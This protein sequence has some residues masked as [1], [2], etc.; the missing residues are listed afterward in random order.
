[1]KNLEHIGYP[2]YCVT[3]DGK[4]FSIL[5]NRFLTLH[6]K[7]DGYVTVGLKR[8]TFYVHRLVILA[9]SPVDDYE[10][11]QVN[12]KDGD[13]SNNR[14]SNLEWSTPQ[15]NSLHAVRTGL[16]PKRN[17]TDEQV[18]SICKMLEDGVKTSEIA[19]V[20]NCPTSTVGA[21]KS[22][23]NFKYISQEYNW[24]SRSRSKS[25]TITKVNAI[26]K[27]F[28]EGFSTKEVATLFNC[29]YAVVSDIR[30]RRT[31]KHF[32]SHLDW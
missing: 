31:F 11:L 25:L 4:V 27:K 23:Q 13:K 16:N 22:G 12:H 9:Y 18:H 26:C 19:E 21:I 10:S 29:R 6:L 1:M 7:S 24:S 5:S 20:F 28:S 14:W 3:S 15:E 30:A 2:E 17:L 8:K 32:T